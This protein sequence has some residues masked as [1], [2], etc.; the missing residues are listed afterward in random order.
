MTPTKDGWYEISV[1]DHKAHFWG[2][3]DTLAVLSAK[4]NNSAA[5]ALPG[6]ETRVVDPDGAILGDGETGELQIRGPSLIAGYLAYSTSSA[7]IWTADGWYKTG[8]EVTVS[9]QSGGTVGYSI[10]GVNQ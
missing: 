7:E 5:I 3:S 2:Q 9:D 4:Q 8:T 6:V 1:A 10:K